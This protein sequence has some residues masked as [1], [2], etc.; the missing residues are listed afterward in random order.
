MKL[1]FMIVSGGQTGA[2][3][4]GLCAARVYGIKTTGW[5]PKGF[6]TL[7]GPKPQYARL[8]N[9]SETESDKYPPRTFANV[10]LGNV[11]FRFAGDFSSPGELLT[12][13]ACKQ[14]HK[15]Y[16]D[17]VYGD[18]L[19]ESV[20]LIQELKPSVI[21]IAGNSEERYPGIFKY[22]FDTLCELFEELKK[23]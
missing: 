11:T 3:Y 9:L 15:P 17:F 19:G 6:K 1:N 4:A 16:R 22:T 10:K 23:V 2:D 5:M 14:L 13:K 21:N 8:F 12:A 20:H 7:E 18:P